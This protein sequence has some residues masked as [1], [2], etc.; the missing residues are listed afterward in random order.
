MGY[1]SIGLRFYCFDRLYSNDTTYLQRINFNYCKLEGK[2]D[3][4]TD[5]NF[6]QY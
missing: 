1:F 6:F 5:F 3:Y 4:V 2:I